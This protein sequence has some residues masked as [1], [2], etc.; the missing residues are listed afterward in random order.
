MPEWR[1]A[2][3]TLW[4]RTGGNVDQTIRICARSVENESESGD[5]DAVSRP[6]QSCRRHLYDALVVRRSV[7]N[8]RRAWTD[9]TPNRTRLRTDAES[10]S[11]R[12][13]FTCKHRRYLV[14]SETRSCLAPERLANGRWEQRHHL[15]EA[16]GRSRIRRQ[17][18]R[19]RFQFLPLLQLEA[20]VEE[21][22]EAWRSS[23]RGEFP[24]HLFFI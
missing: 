18:H 3:R 2:Q 9:G 19:G 5:H 14:G 20:G 21:W 1:Q 16:D 6:Q 15:L 12:R 4:P 22:N 23:F 13:Q 10:Q 17:S 8:S 11:C 7:C 24:A